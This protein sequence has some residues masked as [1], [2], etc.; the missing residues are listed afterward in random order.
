MADS[1]LKVSDVDFDDIRNNL[2][3]FLT[4]QT[5]FRDYDFEGSNLSVLLDVLAYNTHYNAFYLNMLAN[6][7]FLDTAQ[8]RDSIASLAKMLGYVSTSA[9]GPTAQISMTFSGLPSGTTQFTIAKNSKFNTTIDDITYTFVTPK[10][11]TVIDDNGFEITMDI[12][13]GY[14]LVHKF[15]HN[16]A[17]PV[18][19]VIP[20][21][22]VDTSSIV[23][24]VQESADDT[25]TTEW[26]RA[27]NIK[28]VFET[29]EIYFVEEAYD[30]KYEIIFGSGSLG[31]SL[32][33]GNIVIVEY[34]VCN[35]DVANGAKTFSTENLITDVQYG[36]V[37]APTT[38]KNAIGGRFIETPDSVKFNAPRHFQT[39]NRAII[40]EDY[41]R[42]VL[43]ENS[44]LESVVSFGGENADP[45][46]YGK[47]FIAVKPFGEQFT[48][49]SRKAL[50]KNSI[51]DRT[52]LSIDPVIIDP[53]YTY[54]IAN[55][56][57]Y[58]DSSTTKESE[59]QI[60]SAI[61]TAISNFSTNNLERFGQ[62]LRFSKFLSAL[63][64]VNVGKVLNNDA[65]LSLQKR[66]VPNVETAARL[67]LKFA[68]SLK[69]N[70][71]SSS[72]FV[73]RNF[74]CFLDDDGQG[75]VRIYRFDDSKQKVIINATAGT[76]NYNTGTVDVP[77]FAITSYDGI[78]LY[79]TCETLNLDVDPVREQIL[80][81]DPKDATV[82]IIDE[83][84][85]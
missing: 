3:T 47:V 10:A 37:T 31:K 79:I 59:G 20:N 77:N 44:D 7:M 73:Y 8:Q 69:A 17:S 85:R 66:V 53:E 64:A 36:S 41:K 63:D 80:I 45:P 49:E 4:T 29:S 81:V 22:N 26:V 19:F 84:L 51:V 65:K 6:E 34:L 43:A 40:A 57:T 70:S 46:I 78:E 33:N 48:T 68:N 15:T 52:P 24:K 72:R 75:N 32:T 35:G 50:L 14:P 2:K 30:E 12:K 25:T 54:V 56:N 62:R 5:Q 13:E 11:Y 39:Q 21:K 23:V 71:L 38:V 67:L 82:S 83:R 27:T 1:Y 58:Y 9:Q 28:Q 55:I 74:E 42:I 60:R 76:I 16:S 18:R 61:L